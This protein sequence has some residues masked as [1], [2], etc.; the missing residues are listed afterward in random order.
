MNAL[1]KIVAVGAMVVAAASWD[2]LAALA[3]TSADL[4]AKKEICFKN[5]G[6]A[7]AETRA[8]E[9]QRLLARARL[10]VVEVIPSVADV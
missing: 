5:H 6:N 4:A 10:L 8:P 2:T 9:R 7:H 1:R 3:D